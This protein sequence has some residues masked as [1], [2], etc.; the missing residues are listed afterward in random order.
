MPNPHARK[1]DFRRRLVAFLVL[2]LVVGFGGQLASFAL[3]FPPTYFASLWVPGGILLAVLLLRPPQEWA[4]VVLGVIVG[5]AGA[6]MARSTPFHYALAVY[7]L[8]CLAIVAVA[9]MLG[10][11]RS[12]YFHSLA[13]VGRY[14]LLAVVLL[15]AFTGGVSA[16]LATVSGLR[17]GTLQLW[18]VLAPAQSMGFLLLTPMV[19][20]ITE[21]RRALRQGQRL[22]LR[23]TE[24]SLLAAGLLMLSW[25]M[26]AVAPSNPGLLPLLLFAPVPMLLLV[27][28]RLGELGTSVGLLVVGVFAAWLGIYSDGPFSIDDGKFNVHTLQLWLLSVG[29]LVYALSAQS[30]QQRSMRDKLAAS[31][32]RIHELAARLL[33]SHEEERARI[34][35]EL[36]DGVSQQIASF[37][38][39]LSSLKRTEP[40]RVGERLEELHGSMVSL[41]EDV[42][43]I[44]HNLHPAV[45][46]HIGLIRGLKALVEEESKRWSGEIW[47]NCSPDAEPRD[48]TTRLCLYRIAQEA[49]R[50]AARHSRAKNIWLIL[51][52][53]Q[54]D[55]FL[56]LMDDGSGFDI[57]ATHHAGT[58]GLL[59]MEE[60]ALL[61]NGRLCIRS[62]AGNGTSI[63][64]RIP[65]PQPDS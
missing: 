14:F 39:S 50:N 29:C 56:E 54:T 4:S 44:S 22:P 21:Y 40:A 62:R 37:A 8:I 36:H 34:S 55:Y 58:L 16:V 6:L 18:L 10:P 42:R 27:A 46:E 52:R 30:N 41:A 33:K 15:P 11:A 63:S 2:G 23:L 9:R 57:D 17:S 28:L 13:M 35:R 43:R 64:V 48:Y 60:R 45:L 7:L 32:Q 19:V 20:S 31:Q 59:S 65:R 5:G 61:A 3:W 53:D 26:W 1:A 47:F 49:L 12:P 24:A 25:G 51:R 38:I